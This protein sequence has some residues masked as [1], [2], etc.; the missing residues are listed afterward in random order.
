MYDM[1]CDIRYPKYDIQLWNRD[2]RLSEVGD[3]RWGKYRNFQTN[4][5]F[6]QVLPVGIVKIYTNP[7]LSK[8]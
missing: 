2:L 5:D 1:D 7:K 3:S 6:S 8:I 4:L